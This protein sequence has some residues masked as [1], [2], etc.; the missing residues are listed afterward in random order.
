MRQNCN[1]KQDEQ[2]LATVALP[3]NLYD[4]SVYVLVN[5]YLIIEAKVISVDDVHS[6]P[7]HEKYKC[8]RKTSE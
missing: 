1:W 6:F 5:I 3:S 4:N 7:F 2:I 8:N